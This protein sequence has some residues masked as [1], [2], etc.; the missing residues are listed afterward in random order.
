MGFRLRCRQIVQ[1]TGAL[2]ASVFNFQGVC[3]SK[4]FA[5]STPCPGAPIPGQVIELAVVQVG[6]F[7]LCRQLGHIKVEWDRC[8]PP[9]FA[10]YL[11]PRF[12]GVAHPLSR[13]LEL[14]VSPM[15]IDLSCDSKA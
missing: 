6:Q 1:L 11:P 15:R 3:N 10:A 14:A 2:T 9:D 8:A 13:P 12:N 4:C 7:L 5:V